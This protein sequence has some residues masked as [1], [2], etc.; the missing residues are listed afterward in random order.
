MYPCTCCVFNRLYY[1]YNIILCLLATVS[2]NSIHLSTF[3]V[4]LYNCIIMQTQTFTFEIM[5]KNIIISIIVSK[6]PKDDFLYTSHLK[7]VACF[8]SRLLIRTAACVFL[9][10]PIF[11][12]DFRLSVSELSPTVLQVI[13]TGFA[14]LSTIVY[15]RLSTLPKIE[16]CYMLTCLCI[17]DI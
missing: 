15:Q 9:R 17:C 14:S 4:F 1:K 10:L 6:S 3:S 5:F 12:T 2:Q 13:F 11:T 7:K 16:V 8:K